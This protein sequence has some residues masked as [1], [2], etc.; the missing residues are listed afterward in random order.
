VVE[1]RGSLRKLVERYG[2]K[3]QARTYTVEVCLRCRWN[4]LIEVVPLS[5]ALSRR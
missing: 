2:N 5:E 4:H 1:D 3:P